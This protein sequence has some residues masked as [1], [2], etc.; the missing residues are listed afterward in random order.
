M[1]VAMEEAGGEAAAGQVPQ[2]AE[3]DPAA[4]AAAAAALREVVAADAPGFVAALFRQLAHGHPLLGAEG[5]QQRTGRQASSCTCAVAAAAALVWGG[6][7]PPHMLHRW[8]WGRRGAWLVGGGLG[9]PCSPAARPQIRPSCELFNA[10]HPLLSS[11]CPAFFP[12]QAAA[13]HVPRRHDDQDGDQ[14]AGQVGTAVYRCVPL[15]TAAYRRRLVL[16]GWRGVW[17]VLGVEGRRAAE[18]WLRWALRC[19]LS[20]VLLQ[21]LGWDSR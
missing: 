14:D 12:R 5:Q 20:I 11:S 2:Q 9:L 15:C 1:D 4:V 10:R 17:W 7:S 13:G 16:V 19:C 18:A 21:R 8:W 6:A 3:V